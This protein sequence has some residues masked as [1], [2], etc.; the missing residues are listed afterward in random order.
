MTNRDIGIAWFAVE[1]IP[2]IL[3]VVGLGIVA[4]GFEAR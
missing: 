4:R 3:E 2:I 1:G